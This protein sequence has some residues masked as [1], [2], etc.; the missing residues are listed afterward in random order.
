MTVIQSYVWHNQK[1]FFVST[2]ERSCSAQTE[3]P[4]R[5]NETI[6]WESPVDHARGKI[7]FMDDDVAGSIDKHISI[8]KSI[9]ENG[10]EVLNG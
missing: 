7:V 2:I 6:A 5:Y 4:I 9:Y 8:C 1:R 3:V 10:A